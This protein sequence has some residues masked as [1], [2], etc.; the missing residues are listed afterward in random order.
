MI[1][2]A[3]QNHQNER[4]VSDLIRFYE[5]FK[6]AKLASGDQSVSK[7]VME[8]KSWDTV[9]IS[10]CKLKLLL[11][12]NLFPALDSVLEL[13]VRPTAPSTRQ[14][15]SDA[16]GP[17]CCSA[18]SDLVK[19]VTTFYSRANPSKSPYDV[20][21]MVTNHFGEAR[22]SELKFKLLCK[23]GFVP[24][25]ENSGKIAIA[26]MMSLS[27][28]NQPYEWRYESP[29]K[30]RANTRRPLVAIHHHPA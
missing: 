12:Y 13:I 27:G 19:A 30:A 15:K 26:M 10:V 3:Q 22:S 28:S 20:D 8:S 5:R 4:F 2:V 14:G 25:D 24:C 29:V 11:K 18:L 7:L 9:D 21:T 16:T 23:Y 17:A 1:P 6:P